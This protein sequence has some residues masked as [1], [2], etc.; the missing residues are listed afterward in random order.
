MS[1]QR[2]PN[3]LWRTNEL[4]ATSGEPVAQMAKTVSRDT[5]VTRAMLD[6]IREWFERLAQYVNVFFCVLILLRLR[7]SPL[8]IPLKV[9]PWGALCLD[10][11]FYQRCRTRAKPVSSQGTWALLEFITMVVLR[12][13]RVKFSWS[14]TVYGGLFY[15]LYWVRMVPYTDEFM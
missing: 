13:A 6:R 5:I 3:F 12:H 9:K 8:F 10:R 4:T 11:K 14:Q 15:Q 2:A 1:C 7:D